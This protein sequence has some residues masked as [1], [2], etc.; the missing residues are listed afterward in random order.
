M[1]FFTK[2]DKLEA[3]NGGVPVIKP[4]WI[5]NSYI[6]LIT[7][8]TVKPKPPESEYEI[9]VPKAIVAL[10]DG[11]RIKVVVSSKPEFTSAEIASHYINIVESSTSSF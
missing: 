9:D 1:A 8:E 4:V 10:S 11:Q 2:V 7:E 3:L 5:R 6:S